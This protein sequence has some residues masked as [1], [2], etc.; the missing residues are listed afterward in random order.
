MQ[1]PVFTILSAIDLDALKADLGVKDRSIRLVRERK[2]FP[3]SWFPH[4]KRLCDEAGIDC[5]I[6]AFNWKGTAN[7]EV[8]TL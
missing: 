1:A 4:V 6:D 3:A 7:S 8:N 2:V 5:P